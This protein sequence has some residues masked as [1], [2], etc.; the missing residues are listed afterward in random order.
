M[1]A[2]KNVANVTPSAE[3]LAT[4]LVE[5]RDLLQSLAMDHQCFL[6]A[7][8]VSPADIALRLLGRDDHERA[9]LL[10]SLAV[11]TIAA[12]ND[13]MRVQKL[14]NA[15][16]Q[17]PKVFEIVDARSVRRERAAHNQALGD[18]AERLFKRHFQYLLGSI[19]PRSVL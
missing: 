2:G 3:S 13:P 6:E 15:I 1:G 4:L 9:S 12:D 11:I 10:Q 16:E 7:L 5:E 14:A 19:V 8:G 18:V 17:D